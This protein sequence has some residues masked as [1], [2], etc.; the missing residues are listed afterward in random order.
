[1]IEHELLLKVLPLGNLK[2]IL[3]DKYED[4]LEIDLELNRMDKI[5]KIMSNFQLNDTTRCDK[6]DEV[7]NFD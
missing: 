2:N 3:G 1:M 7:L 6:I 5:R 4:Y